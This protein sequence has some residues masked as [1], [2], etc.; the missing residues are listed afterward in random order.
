MRIPASGRSQA[1]FWLGILATFLVIMYHGPISQH[2]TISERPSLR[3][4][5][6][7]Q[8]VTVM[9]EVDAHGGAVKLTETAP[10]PKKSVVEAEVDPGVFTTICKDRLQQLNSIRGLSE[11]CRKVLL[12][13]V[14]DQVREKRHKRAADLA[15]KAA[16]NSQA[17]LDSG[18]QLEEKET[19]SDHKDSIDHD[20]ESQADTESKTPEDA[21][22]EAVDNSMSVP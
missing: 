22:T 11:R 18:L 8:R 1:L 5:K 13:Y 15:A 21:A 9:P 17:Q 14:K 20:L 6:S 16:A 7:Q 3:E 4:D 2:R 10:P 19:S 12:M